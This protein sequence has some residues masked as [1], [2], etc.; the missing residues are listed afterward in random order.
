[1]PSDDRLED[2]LSSEDLQ[3]LIEESQVSATPEQLRA[4]LAFIE[5]AG[6]IEEAQELLEELRKAA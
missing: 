4:I 5:Q 6:G 2:Q 3:E 1:M